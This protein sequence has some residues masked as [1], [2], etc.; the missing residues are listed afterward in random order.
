ME[1]LTYGT[2]LLVT[3]E[4][5]NKLAVWGKRGEDQAARSNDDLTVGN[6]G[7]E[8]S[9]NTQARDSFSSKQLLALKVSHPFEVLY[10][11]EMIPPGFCPQ[12]RL[13]LGS[14]T[15]CVDTTGLA[16]SNS[17]ENCY[18]SLRVAVL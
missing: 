16:Y 13:C 3:R 6:L 11:N 15:K 12:I 8:R 4:K 10:T 18:T 9:C 1:T 5:Q 7:E 2:D 17:R 14:N